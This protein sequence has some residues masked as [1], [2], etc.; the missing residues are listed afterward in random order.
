MNASPRAL[1]L[2]LLLGAGGA[3][4]GAREAV[5]ACALMGVQEG[6]TRVALAR[7][8]AAGMLQPGGRGLYTLG[9]AAQPLA[10]DVAT[11]RAGEQRVRPWLGDWVAV[12]AGALG[13]SDRAALRSRERALDLLGLAEL[14]RGLYLRPDNLAGG[15]AGVRARLASLCPQSDL[16]VPGRDARGVQRRP[17]AGRLQPLYL[18]DNALR[19]AVQR[20]GA[21]WA[22]EALT[23]LRRAHR[24]RRLHRARRAGQPHPPELDTH[25]R[26]GRRI[27]LVRFHP[28]YHRLMKTAVEHGLHLALDRPRPGAHVAR[29]AHT[30]LQSRSR[31]ATAARSR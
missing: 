27:D 4:L 25:D 19:E 20:E 29:A 5:A 28:A 16:T 1:I 21:A 31:P 23:P 24:Q 3:P 22:Q 13:R 14:E 8:V 12:H 11:W 26:F 6:S 30:Y 15:V 10:A 9:A 18:Q 17:R 7:L 2:N